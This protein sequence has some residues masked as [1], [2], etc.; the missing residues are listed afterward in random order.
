ME[1]LTPVSVSRKTSKEGRLK[2]TPVRYVGVNQVTGLVRLVPRR[3][4]QTVFK[5]WLRL[6]E[7]SAWR[8]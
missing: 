5:R 4:G 3:D 2:L 6:R 1:G 7:S 8:E